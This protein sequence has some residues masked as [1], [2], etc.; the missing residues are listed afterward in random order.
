M[1][2]R[3]SPLIFLGAFAAA[4]HF[5]SHSAAIPPVSTTAIGHLASSPEHRAEPLPSPAPCLPDDGTADPSVDALL[6]RSASEF[7][8]E[9]FARALDCAMEAA[10]TEPQS[11]AAHHYRGAALAELGRLDE[12]KLAY[13]HAL[14]LDPQDPELLRSLADFFVRRLGG[15]EELETATIYCARA[16]P[17]ARANGDTELEA[18]LEL[19]QSMAL[20]DLGRPTEALPAATRALELNTSDT[21]ARRERG[22][23]LFELVRIPEAESELTK[24]VA[25]GADPLAEHYLGLIAERRGDDR[26]AHERFARALVLD[27][28]AFFEPVSVPA[29]PFASMVEDVRRQ[30]PHEVQQDLAQAHLL[31]EELP[32]SDDLLA[33]VPPLSPTILGLF[34]P[35]PENAPQSEKPAIV[36]YRR[37]LERACH[38]QA[39]LR[40][41]VRD[42]MLHEIGHLRGEDDDELRDRGL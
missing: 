20:D 41:E 10:R 21:E 11:V 17:L 36:L 4:C 8:A 1:T 2:L 15:R 30:L 38:D 42:T 16:V 18:E 29:Q 24:V 31:I 5:Q 39:E 12:A 13:A 19:L 33:V 25:D 40:R 23:A 35:P 9:R 37:N 34:R 28:E 6:E 22:V 26:N 27:P 14:A 32:Q 3:F 7:S